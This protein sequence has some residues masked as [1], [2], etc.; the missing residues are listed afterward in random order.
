M[1]S[2]VDRRRRIVVG[3][4]IVVAVAIG[5]VAAASLSATSDGGVGAQG[6]SAETSATVQ[7][8]FAAMSLPEAIASADAIV[9][10]RVDQPPWTSRGVQVS[11]WGRE[12]QRALGMTDEEIDRQARR[13]DDIVY[14]NSRFQIERA[15]KGDFPDGWVEVRCYGGQ[16]RG[17][18]LHAP[19][20]PQ[21]QPGVR[22]VVFL[23]RA[24]DGGYEPVA[25]YAIAGQMASTDHQ[26]RHDRMPLDQLIAEIEAHRDDPNPFDP[27]EA[28]TTRSDRDTDEEES[29]PTTEP[30]APTHGP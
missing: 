17:Y 16:F 13:F 23:G 26:G 12:R 11:Q 1:T 22:C 18:R 7:A 9:L 5:A 2:T 25:V 27:L 15:L 6:N 19:G 14:T 4:V 3:L 24:F 30:A 28:G 20:F 10:G 29:S 8:S 21:L